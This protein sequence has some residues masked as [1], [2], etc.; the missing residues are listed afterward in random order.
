MALRFVLTARESELTLVQACIAQEGD[1]VILIG[2]RL[3]TRN[4]GTDVPSYEYESH[5]RKVIL[6]G[7]VGIGFEGD[8]VLIDKFVSELS[9]K[10][11]YDSIIESIAEGIKEEDKRATDRYVKSRTG[12][13]AKQF[14]ERTDAKVP[15]YLVDEVYEGIEECIDIGALIAGYDRSGNPRLTVADAE[16][17]VL[18]FTNLGNVS[19]GSGSTLSGI[20]FDQNRYDPSMNEDEALLFAFEA[21]KWAEAHTGVGHSTDII[22]IKRRGKPREILEESPLMEKMNRIYEEE[23]RKQ[24]EVRKKLLRKMFR[25]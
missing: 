23:G 2:D 10:R 9:G 16:G 20:Y 3:V 4:I 15:D 11:D 21:K 17:D 22:I 14:F 18:N 24:K 6:K 25:E 19:I 12:L 5:N 13:S 7:T 1:R 8:V